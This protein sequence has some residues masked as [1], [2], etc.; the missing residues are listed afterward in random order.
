[1]TAGTFG[2]G[3]AAFRPRGRPRPSFILNPMGLLL[4]FAV[5]TAIPARAQNRAAARIEAPAVSLA[6][7]AAS[8]L[9]A[10]ASS[11]QP[12]AAAPSLAPAPAVPASL[13]AAVPAAVPLAAAPRAAAPAA[14]P[15]RVAVMTAGVA[16]AAAALG[17]GRATSAQAASAGRDIEDLLTGASSAGGAA[18]PAASAEELDFAAGAGT[19]LGRRAD[20]LG[21][22]R[23]M[24]AASMSGADFIALA[25]DSRRAADAEP[26]PTPAAGE[27]ARAVRA[28]LL[29]VV[30]ALT[31]A[32]APLSG[33]V[34]RTLAVWQVFDQELAAAAKGG[35]LRAVAA[36]AEL[37]AS[38]VEASVE[39]PAA[40]ARTDLAPARPRPE[41][42]DGYAEVAVPGSVFGWRPIEDSPG[43][44][45]PPADALIRR[46]LSER[47]DPARDAGFELAGAPSRAAARVY[48]YGERHDDGALITENMRRLVEDAR[49]GGRII[50]LVE[51]YT[52]WRLQG[53]AAVKYLAD[54]GLDPEALAA[55]GVTIDRVQVRGWDTLD[56]YGASKHPLLQHHME[57]LELNRLAHEGPRGLR[58]YRD[59]ARAAWAAV[60]GW[61]ALW[62]AAIVA[63]NADLD[64]AVAAAADDA[65]A[66]GATVHVIAG[67]DHLV[68]H[69]RLGMFF[70]RLA[71][72]RFRASL[73]AALGGRPY[74][75]SRPVSR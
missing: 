74:W 60:Q 59:F 6:A 31:P 75:A 40:P 10:L 16:K 73:A 36:E 30:R 57:L 21:A 22:A 38:Q 52:D 42:P 13:A 72:P 46:A 64:R 2:V 56:G 8:A 44:G 50:V 63:R 29:R 25:E 66:N 5:L 32:D 18:E 67:S 4:W 71:R 54:R 48:F 49:P 35:S 65:D 11:I 39:P 41:D 17:G 47:H 53:W 55:K 43:H 15:A 3:H 69:P 33:G 9:P 28:A 7:P 27:A 14:A 34:R 20:D 24:K 45:L 51:G 62:S 26:A 37:F 19:D 61:R 12:M 68:Q 58:Y 70:P 23:G 1:M